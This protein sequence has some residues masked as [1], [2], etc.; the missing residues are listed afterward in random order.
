MQLR[1]SVNKRRILNKGSKKKILIHLS[2][3]V[4]F[5]HDII[6]NRT[7]FSP[8]FPLAEVVE[9]V[10]PFVLPLEYLMGWS[11]QTQYEDETYKIHH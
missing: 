6:R 9:V 10:G 2:F 1:R 7:Y 4:Y 5:L 8:M 11:G 3:H